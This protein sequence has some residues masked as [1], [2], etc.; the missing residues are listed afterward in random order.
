[1]KKDIHPESY[2]PVVFRDATAGEAFLTRSTV[3][4]EK[5]IEWEDGNEYPL[6]EL[7]ISAFSHPFYTG[8]ERLVDTEGRIDKFKKKYAMAAQNR[9]AKKKKK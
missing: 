4:T 1:M 2:R 8:S 9:G 5:T 3:P 7:A 6:Y